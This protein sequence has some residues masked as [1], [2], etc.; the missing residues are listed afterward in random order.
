MNKKN[1]MNNDIEEKY[2][3]YDCYPTDSE[4]N[5]Y[6]YIEKISSKKSDG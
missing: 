5:E 6:L 4:K 1:G 2:V 3:I